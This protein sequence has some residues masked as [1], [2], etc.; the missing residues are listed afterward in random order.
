MLYERMLAESKRLENQIHLLDSQLKTLP[1]VNLYC[2]RNGTNY[3]W[4]TN[5]GKKTSYLPKKELQFA[6]KLALRKYLSLLREDLMHEKQAIDSY[7]TYHNSDVGQAAKLLCDCPE[8]SKLISPYNTSLSLNLSQWMTSPYE[9]NPKFPEQLTHK[10]MSGNLVRSKSEV[11]IDMF[12]YTNKIPFRY[13]CALYLDHIV[14]FPDFTIRHPQNGSIFYWEH[15]GMMDDQSYYKNAYSKLQLY[16]SHG[17]IPSINLIV[18]YETKECPL[19]AE[20]VQKTI[21]HY[22]L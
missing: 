9:K 19:N 21:E 16:T 12:L 5:D 13:E 11:I 2:C 22:F 10:T 14:L 17:I 3:K 15:F 20:L 4:Y 8:Y 1:Q 6:Q 7:L 18:T